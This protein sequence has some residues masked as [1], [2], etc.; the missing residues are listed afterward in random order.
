M[1]AADPGVIRM[2]RRELPEIPVHVST[3]ANTSNSES[4]RFWRECGAKRVNVAREL[5][6]QE[7]MEM[8]AVSRKQMAN[9][10]LEVVITSYSIHYTKLYDPP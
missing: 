8:L 3:Q 6:S 1:I 10:E 4:V 2:L 5:R 7:L 9:M